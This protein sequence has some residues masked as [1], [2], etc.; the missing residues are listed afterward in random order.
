[1]T[2]DLSEGHVA[3]RAKRERAVDPAESKNPGMQRNFMREN[4]ETPLP[5]VAVERAGGSTR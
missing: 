3:V 2:S 4:R 1:M 5:P